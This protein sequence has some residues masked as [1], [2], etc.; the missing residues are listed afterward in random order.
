MWLAPTRLA[1]ALAGG[2]AHKAQRDLSEGFIVVETNYRVACHLP[3][4][5]TCRVFVVANPSARL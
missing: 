1:L 3:V 5:W 4:V 2:V